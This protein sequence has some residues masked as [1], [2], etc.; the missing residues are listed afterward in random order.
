MKTYRQLVEILNERMR[1]NMWKALFSFLLMSVLET[2]ILS[3]FSIP[4][5]ASLSVDGSSGGNIGSLIFSLISIYCG[6]VFVMLLQYGYQ[7]ILLRLLRGKFVTLGFLFNG[8]R[9]R[10]R[11]GRASALFSVGFIISFILCQITVLAVNHFYPDFFKNIN[12]TELVALVF[13]LY[14]FFSI[15]LLIRFAFVWVY[16]AD[17]PEEKIAAVFKRC[18]S[19]LKNHT[20]KLIGFVLYAGGRRLLTAVAIIILSLFVPEKTEGAAGFL[21]SIIEVCYFISAYTAAVR[22]FAAVPLYYLNLTAY[23]FD[24]DSSVLQLE[25]PHLQLP[26]NPE[27]G[28]DAGSGQQ[29]P[30]ADQNNSEIQNN[31]GGQG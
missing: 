30:S 23:K 17:F 13:L 26:E 7:V 16:L 24:S 5:M 25:A 29:V 28:G 10:K 27:S 18:F 4:A 11:I 19:L 21:Y 9:E 1:T 6:F 15:I 31:S 22:M 12:F 20:F 2:I 8:F 3:A 14:V